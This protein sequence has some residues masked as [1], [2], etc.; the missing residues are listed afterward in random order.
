MFTFSNHKSSLLLCVFV[1]RK[2]TP[3]AVAFVNRVESNVLIYWPLAS[4]R[5]YPYNLV[6]LPNGAGAVHCKCY[7]CDD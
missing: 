1:I 3:G 6:M 4:R 2:V 7:S 5:N